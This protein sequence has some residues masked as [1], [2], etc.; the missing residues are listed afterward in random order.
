VAYTYYWISG[1][2]AIVP[3]L[4]F[5]TTTRFSDGSAGD[6]TT[7]E[8]VTVAAGS[9]PPAVNTQISAVVDLGTTL[10][11]SGISGTARGSLL[12]SVFEPDPETRFATMTFYYWDGTAWQVLGSGSLGTPTGLFVTVTPTLGATVDT[13]YIKALCRVYDSTVVSDTYNA[14]AAISDLRIT[15]ACIPPGA[16][17]I[18]GPGDCEGIQNT[19]TWSSVEGATSYQ[20]R[21]DGGAPISV[22]LALTYVHTPVAI[23]SSHTYEVRALNA[24]GSGDWSSLVTVVA[25][26]DPG[27]CH[28]TWTPTGKPTG[29]ASPATHDCTPATPATH[30]ATASSPRTCA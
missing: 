24:C 19:I 4:G 20:L 17:T 13:R 30:P 26:G 16:P 22:G 23:D 28:C 6:T 29:A 7:E 11:V 8:R 18:A 9:R 25:C 27:V 14:Y 12:Y 10:R 21:I 5:A 15:A 3:P 1:D 2:T